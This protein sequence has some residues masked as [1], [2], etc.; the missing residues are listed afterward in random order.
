M[1]EIEFKAFCDGCGEFLGSIVA[2]GTGIDA[3]KIT[4]SDLNKA[5]TNTGVMERV[6][7]KR[8]TKHF[9]RDCADGHKKT[10]STAHE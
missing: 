6:L 7:M 9:C 3:L 2:D 8:K 1:I 10:T 4:R 5:L